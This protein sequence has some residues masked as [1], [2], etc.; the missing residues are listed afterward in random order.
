MTECNARG[1]GAAEWSA[2]VRRSAKAQLGR[3]T[4]AALEMGP[5]KALRVLTIGRH[6]EN[7]RTSS[8]HEDWPLCWS[9][10]RR[11]VRPHGWS[12]D[13]GGRFRIGME[14]R[15]QPEHWAIAKQSPHGD[16]VHECVELLGGGW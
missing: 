12:A 7:G 9:S 13:R 1:D 6:A 16:G 3:G 4:A 14:H 8:F 10:S 2:G 5:L 15:D 11:A